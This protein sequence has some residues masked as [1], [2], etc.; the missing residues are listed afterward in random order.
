MVQYLA[1]LW[2]ALC[3]SVL[4]STALHDCT[5]WTLESVLTIQLQNQQFPDPW[6]SISIEN[7]QYLAHHAMDPLRFVST[8]PNGGAVSPTDKPCMGHQCLAFL[9]HGC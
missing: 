6:H 5:E 8:S 2:Y 1:L 4:S 9:A 7:E 3:S